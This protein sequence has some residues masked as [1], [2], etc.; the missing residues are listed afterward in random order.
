MKSRRDGIGLLQDV[1]ACGVR[2]AS[3]FVIAANIMRSLG[4]SRKKSPFMTDTV[5]SALAMSG[6]VPVDARV[7]LSHV[8]GCDR[9]WLA[10]HRDAALDATQRTAFQALAR[11][12]RDGEPVAYLTGRREFHG[13]ELEVTPDVLIPRPETELLVEMA[14]ERADREATLDVLDLGTGSGAVALA[15]AHE[16]PR[17]RVTGI[18]VST[19]ALEVARRNAQRLGVV[20]VE[21]LQSDW[22]AALG[23]RRFDLIVANPPYVASGDDYLTQGDLRFEPQVALA[24]GADGLDAIRHI[25]A[26]AHARLRDHGW[27]ALEHGYDQAER[28][29]T[30]LGDERFDRIASRRDL[31]GIERVT[32]GRVAAVGQ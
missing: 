13:L 17:W 19:A 28:V 8:L 7:L 5:S 20:G 15:I 18:D 10:A 26:D 24:S 4:L 22:Y 12:R 6:L 29:R 2:G 16:R 11:R 9:A 14:L 1:S 32:T 23:E 21:W 25:V 30:L 27:L 3:I 31:A